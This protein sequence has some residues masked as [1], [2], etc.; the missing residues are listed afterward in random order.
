VNPYTLHNTLNL[1][2]TRRYPAPKKHVLTYQQ[3]VDTNPPTSLRGDPDTSTWLTR[4]EASEL[5]GCSSSTLLNYERRGALHPQIALRPDPHG[6]HRRTTVYHPD[7]LTKIKARLKRPVREPNEFSARAFDLFRAGHKLEEIVSE[8]RT[9]PEEIERLHEKW[10]DL[11]GS[12]LVIAGPAKEA[13]AKIFGPFDSVTEL[14]E[15][16]TTKLKPP[17]ET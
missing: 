12:R 8:L 5:I 9:T 15:L 7:E 14:I 13:L 4:Y 17:S 10:L 11:G 3:K 16:A 2:V 6:I 1:S